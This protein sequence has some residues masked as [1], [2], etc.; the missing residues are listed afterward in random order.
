MYPYKFDPILKS[1]LWGGNKIIP[2][3]RLDSRQQQVGE[4]WEISGVRGNESVVR[5]GKD[6]GKT[7]TE[8]VQEYRESLVGRSNYR[9]F[10]DT[11]PLLIKFIDARNDLSIQVHPNDELAQKR[12]H[13]M[14]KT[15]MWYIIDNAHGKARLYAGLKRRITPDEYAEMVE[16]HTI[17]DAL[18]T[19]SVKPNEVFFLPA[20]RI[21]S[22]G[23]GCFLAEIQQTSDITY[24]IYDFDR[25]D[26][27]GN[28]RELHTELAK[29][30]IDY[31][32][33]P[34]YRTAY[35]PRRNE[36]VELI[37]CPYFTTSVYDLTES[38]TVD[39][40]ELDSFVIYICIAGTCTITDDERNELPLQAGESILFPA[41]VKEVQIDVE[42][43]VKFLESYV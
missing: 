41:T 40:R 30:A 24:R 16:K 10:G 27:E 38:M 3:K 5:N 17:V 33:L 9:R 34:D 42:T 20:G 13:S 22:I 4:S 19:Y 23:R 11:F 31:T 43:H 6:T 36:S 15:E 18:A 29:E 25:K 39:Y 32:V 14:G 1:T 21:H 7:L 35:A 2:F 8:L 28:T 12:H 37:S 26:E